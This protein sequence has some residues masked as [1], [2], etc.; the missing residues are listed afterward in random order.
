MAAVVL[1]VRRRKRKEQFAKE[2]RLEQI[3]EAPKKEPFILPPDPAVVEGLK[4]PG[5]HIDVQEEKP[6][7]GKERL[8]PP[9][10]PPPPPRTKSL[11]AVEH[12]RLRDVLRTRSFRS[13]PTA[14]EN[15][16]DNPPQNGEK[17]LLDGVDLF[18][19]DF[20]YRSQTSANRAKSSWTFDR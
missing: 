11:P 12:L 15:A 14:P 8:S 13:A 19:H 17:A 2:G 5:E 6:S 10:P 7:K 18:P 4:K 3:D 20:A 16:N 9:Y 1:I